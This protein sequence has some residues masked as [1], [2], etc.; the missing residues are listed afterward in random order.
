MDKVY[1]EDCVQG[2][3]D[4]FDDAIIDLMICDPP[5]GIGESKFHRHYN[6]D[7]TNIIDGYQE[8]PPDYAS[9]TNKWLMQAKRI[10]K[11]NGSMYIVS[12]WTNIH[13]ILNSIDKLKLYLINH[14]IW[15]FNFGVATKQKF[16][17]SHYHILYVKKSK[18][19]TPVFNTF[20]RFGS[21]EKNK[22]GGS[23]LYQDLEDVWII[24][25]E[26]QPGKI[27]NKN[28]LPNELIQKM[29]LYS[30]NKNDIVCDFFLGNFTTAIVAKNLG[31]IAYGFEINKQSFEH[32]TKNLENTEFGKGLESLKKVNIDLPPNQ[33]KSITNEEK[34]KIINDFLDLKKNGNTKKFAIQKLTE[35]YGRGY[36]SIVNILKK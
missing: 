7:E 13:H 1:N 31:R 12:G 15:K 6:R 9:F 32:G 17:S 20:C 34:E 10:L 26:Y 3:I 11:K 27:K 35:K 2:S 14:I 29:I 23:L 25:K 30:S 19:A 36:F 21:K 8:S 18:N 24:N 22:N 16:V 4:Y 33:G 5:F 28:K